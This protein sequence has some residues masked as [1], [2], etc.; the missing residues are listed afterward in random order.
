MANEYS[1]SIVSTEKRIFPNQNRHHNFLFGKSETI[2]GSKTYPGANHFIEAYEKTAGTKNDRTRMAASQKRKD[3][4]Y[5]RIDNYARHHRVT[6]AEVEYAQYAEQLK[7][8]VSK[9]LLR[10]LVMVNTGSFSTTKTDMAWMPTISTESII[11]KSPLCM[12]CNILAALLK[13]LVILSM[14]NYIYMTR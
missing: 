4:I 3:D 11:E 7:Y 6:V 14:Q 12:R 9:R 10:H 1:V 5:R 13:L 2:L 8:T